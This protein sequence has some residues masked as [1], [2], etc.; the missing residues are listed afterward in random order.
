MHKNI[1]SIESVEVSAEIQYQFTLHLLNMY[2]ASMRISGR[3]V[4]LTQKN[5]LY[6]VE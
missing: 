5:I 3:T 6:L 4:A 1:V 2:S